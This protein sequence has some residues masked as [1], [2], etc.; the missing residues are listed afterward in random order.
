RMDL[1]EEARLAILLQRARLG[2]HDRLA[3]QQALVMLTLGGPAALGI[4]N[5][6]GSLDVGK[7]AD[8][9]AFPLDS[10][11]PTRDPVTAAL[12][13]LP[14]SRASFVAVAGRPLV[15]DG[16]LLHADRMLERRVQ[17]SADAL[18]RWYSEERERAQGARDSI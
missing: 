4:E 12:F 9:A 18:D 17:E 1:L 5:E 2:S 11:I 8:L 14:G 15:V 7:A 3:A 13:A 10:A 6:T 16:A